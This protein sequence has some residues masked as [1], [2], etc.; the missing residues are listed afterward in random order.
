MPILAGEFLY[1]NKMMS[2]HQIGVG[3]RAGMVT[4]YW[5]HPEADPLEFFSDGCSVI[6][7]TK[8]HLF[9]NF[10][11]KEDNFGDFLVFTT[12]FLL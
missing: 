12:N 10:D 1:P 2:A 8:K 7:C 6:S 3:H 5:T 11:P 9:N 4:P